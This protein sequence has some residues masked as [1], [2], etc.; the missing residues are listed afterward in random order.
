MVTFGHGKLDDTSGGVPP[1]PACIACGLIYKSL[2]RTGQAVPMACQACFERHCWN[3]TVA[4]TPKNPSFN[5]T[6]FLEPNEGF[7]VW[8]STVWT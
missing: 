7:E 3:G 5:P 4:D 2:L 1:F 8:N 6:L